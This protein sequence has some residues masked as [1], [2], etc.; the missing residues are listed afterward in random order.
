[1]DDLKA[2]PLNKLVSMLKF[3]LDC[4]WEDI[5]WLLTLHRILNSRRQ[6][7]TPDSLRKLDIT[8]Y[9]NFDF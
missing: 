5:V 8:D 2:V 1:M 4:S 9:N 7:F 6:P 3:S